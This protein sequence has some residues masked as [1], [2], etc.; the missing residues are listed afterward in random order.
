M[1]IKKHE[2]L[3]FLLGL[4]NFIYYK[5]F[6]LI[7]FLEAIA[8]LFLILKFIFV[9]K[10]IKVAV[11]Q[12]RKYFKW[13][14]LFGS[15]WLVAQ[16][17]SDL[18]NNTDSTNTIKILA[19]IIVIMILIYWA[20]N[21]FQL[22]KSRLNAFL[23]GYCLSMVPNY[24]LTPNILIQFEP[25]KFCFGPGFTM[26]LFLW[27]SKKRVTLP[28]QILTIIPLTYLDILWGSRALALVTFISWVSCVISRLVVANKVNIFTS[29]LALIIAGLL[30][31]SFYHQMAMS[32]SLGT[33]QQEKAI[34]Q[35]GSGPLILVA[36]SE[37]LYELATLRSHILIGTGSN[38]IISTEI[39]NEVSNLNLKLGVD[40]KNTTAYQYLKSTGKIPKHSLLFS[41]WMTGGI[42]GALFWIY[43]FLML[44]NWTIKTKIG[45]AEYFYLSRF[46]YVGFIWNFL[47]SPLGAGQRV[48]LAI[49]VATIY[50][51]YSG[52]H[53]SKL[54]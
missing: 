6:G 31:S 42:L 16:L 13:F 10:S 7:I 37:L 49:T 34:Q 38:P 43:L 50:R 44:S 3:S 4:S 2:R 35:F 41:F 33:Y 26:L 5:S 28:I 21:W 52:R 54:D 32:G 12:D 27:Y 1:T 40:T 36:R 19:Q 29:F 18:I 17:F 30:L 48:L 24:F 23:L 15:M 45:T 39:L 22:E 20:M 8:V 47:F 51:D 11:D 46:L 14:Y 53:T 9:S 25:W